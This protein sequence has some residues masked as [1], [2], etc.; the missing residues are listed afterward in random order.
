MS[1]N[2]EPGMTRKFETSGI[3]DAINTVKTGANIQY[4]AQRSIILNPGFKVENGAI[5]KAYID[6]CGG[7]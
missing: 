2:L 4:D 7:L 3:M 5:F 6:G 1:L